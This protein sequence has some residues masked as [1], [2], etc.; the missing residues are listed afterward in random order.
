MKKTTL[1]LFI[2]L[3]TV[4]AHAQVSYT[5][6]FSA[7]N[8]SIDTIKASDNNVYTKVSLN[9]YYCHTTNISEPELP[10][11]TIQLIIPYGQTVNSVSVSHV[12]RG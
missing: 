4:L 11:R 1:T 9:N 8:L 12:L 10:T 6:T 7:N 5:A 3:A 2:I